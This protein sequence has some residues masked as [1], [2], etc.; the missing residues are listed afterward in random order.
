MATARLLVRLKDGACSQCGGQLE[1]VDC[2]EDDMEVSCTVCGEGW[3][4][5][6]DAFN[7]GAVIYHLNAMMHFGLLDD[8][9]ED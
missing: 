2:T 3:T 7:D 1:I 4:A 5:E 8:C 6:T 9:F